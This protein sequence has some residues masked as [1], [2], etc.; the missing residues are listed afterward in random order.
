MYCIIGSHNHDI[1]ESC[2]FT[3]ITGICITIP[4]YTFHHTL[5]CGD[6][7]SAEPH[8]EKDIE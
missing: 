8:T 1:K 2:Y 4:K 3:H 5:D 6:L 7:Q